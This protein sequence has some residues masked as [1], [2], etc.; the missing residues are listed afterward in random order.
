MWPSVR[1]PRTHPENLPNPTLCDD[2]ASFHDARRK[3][4]CF[5]I[6]IQS[7]G[8]ASSPE[9]GIRLPGCARQ[10]FRAYLITLRTRKRQRNR[11]TLLARNADH[12]EVDIVWLSKLVELYRWY[13]NRAFVRELPCA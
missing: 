12:G 1:L 7:G 13:W 8:T 11:Q 5:G 4:L 10:G 2:L 6:A 3:D 9:H